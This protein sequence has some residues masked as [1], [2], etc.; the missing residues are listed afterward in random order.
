MNKIIFS[1]VIPV[2][3][4]NSNLEE[5]VPAIINMDYENYEIIILPDNIQK[6]TPSYLKNKK[7]RILQT[8]RV[9][10]A[11]KRDLGVKKSKGKYVA[12]IDDDAYPS[13]NWLKIAE[14]VLKEKKVAAIGGPGITPDSD[15]FS[16]KSSG[17]VFETLF[18]GGGYSYRYTPSKSSFYVDD[19][20]SV[21]LIVEKKAFLEAGGFSCNFWPGEDTKF[22]LELTKRGHKIF[23]SNELI[24]YH[25]RRPGVIK[26]LKQVSN[27]GKHRGYFAK[28]FPENSLKIEYF[29][30]SAFALGNVIL[31][32]L[33]LFSSFFLKTWLILLV[34]YF[35]LV[36]IDVFVRTKKILLGLFSVCLVF[37]T[38]LVYGISFI[39]GILSSNLRSKLR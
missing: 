37:L 15:K 2:K 25:H 28:K 35:S 8:G 18:G 17:L 7:I 38:H 22:C 21:N 29:A 14:R 32:I 5:S 3:E 26:H 33:S 27:Y 12:F 4:L 16:A 9:S 24:V 13:K 34:V 31:F 19:F 1:I 11:I 20:P 23:Y 39:K 36:I 10:P 6:E 30:P